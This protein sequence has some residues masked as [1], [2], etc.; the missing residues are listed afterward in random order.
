MT[1]PISDPFVENVISPDVN[2]APVDLDASQDGVARVTLNRPHSRNA[3]DGPVIAALTEIFETLKGAEGVRIVFLQ[4]AGGHFS[5]GHDHDWMRMGVDWSEDDNRGDAMA[6][7]T[8]LK[9]LADLPALTVA[10]VEGA[11]FGVGAGLV[12]ACDMAIATAEATFAFTEVKL[13]LVPATVSPYVVRAIGPRQA[14][15]LFATG[16][17][18]DAAHAREIGLVHGVVADRAALDAAKAALADQIKTSGP[19]AVDEIKQLVR[20]VTGA[21]INHGLLEDVAKRQARARFTDEGREGMAAVLDGRP[22]S[23][24]VG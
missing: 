10:L 19:R 12:A 7:A 18:I 4:G 11:A 24:A 14:T 22:P 2:A 5:V 15:V 9:T 13:G 6:V 23:W 1:N 21:P 8:L 17:V 20:H 16:H 3:F